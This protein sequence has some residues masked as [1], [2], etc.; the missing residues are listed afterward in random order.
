MLL[1]DEQGVVLSGLGWDVEQDRGFRCSSWQPGQ[2][3]RWRPTSVASLG[4]SP[5]TTNAARF[6]WIS[7]HFIVRSPRSIPER[8]LPAQAPE[9]A[10]G[11]ALEGAQGT[12]VRSDISLWESPPK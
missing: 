2:G 7:V 12:P 10:S 4:S 8:K 1:G 6:A 5:P 9:G 11:S 3:D